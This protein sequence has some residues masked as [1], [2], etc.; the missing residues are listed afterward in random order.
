MIDQ[1]PFNRPFIAGKELFYMA[2]AVVEGQLAGRGTYTRRCEAWLREKFAA[3]HPLLTHTCTA[4]LEMAALLAGL[5]PGDEVILPSFTFVSTANAFALRGAT[6]RFVDIRPDTLNLDETLLEAAINERTRAIVPV[7]YAGVACAMDEILATAAKHDLLVIEDAAQAVGATY[8][9]RHLG[10]L[11]HFGCYSFHETK[12]LISGEGGALLVNDPDL[13]E[14]AEI[15][16]EKGTNRTRFLR[17]EVDRYVWVGL[18]S[19]Y[20]PSEL[21]A[22]F[23]YAQLESADQITRDRRAVWEAYRQAFT[24]FAERGLLRV[25]AV[26]VGCEHNAHMFYLILPTD[27]ARDHLIDALR[28]AGIQAVFHFVPLHSSPMAARLGCRG[29]PLPMTD[30]LAA[31]LVRLPCY[32]GMTP[33]DQDRVIAAVMAAVSTSVRRELVPAGA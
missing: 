21:V 23:L 10:T 18:G 7:H 26:P 20:A 32:Y 6:L 28:E 14:R 33:Q 5:G 31:R 2:N 11:G 8:H 27:E 19:S 16:Y 13:W 17:G 15:C 22:A 3:R 25:P 4:A 12:N 9:G 24:P 1:I 29:G 30:D